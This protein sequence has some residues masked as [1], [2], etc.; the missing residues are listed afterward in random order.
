MSNLVQR[1]IRLAPKPLSE[2]EN[3]TGNPGEVF[4]DANTLSLRIFNGRHSGGYELLR[5][6]FSNIN[7][8]SVD[9]GNR[10]LSATSFAGSVTG[11][12]TGNLTG[13][14][15]GNLTGNVTGNVTGD[16]TGNVN[17]NAATVTNGIYDNQTYENPS[18]LGSV[19]GSK[20]TG[21]VSVNAATATALDTARS[22]NNVSFD[23]T[24]D[25]TVPTLVNGL[26]TVS[27]ASNGNVTVPNVIKLGTV[28]SVS[29]ESTNVIVEGISGN[30]GIRTGSTKNWTFNSAGTLTAPGNITTSTGTVTAAA[31]TVSN[32]VAAGS[33]V[34]SN[35]V[36]VGANVNIPTLPTE[37]QHATNKSYV[38]TRALVMS[39]ALS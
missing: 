13:N 10:A 21:P 2:L 35:D 38:D 9:F 4:L 28:A 37:V 33:A 27:L 1:S 16:L 30:V 24:A 8:T 39:V 23:G 7:G 31:A 18:W 29:S 25:I 17:G 11:N 6:D 19:A 22:I 36:T 5:A 15:T 32:Q 20:I 14:V 3:F 34:V 12:V 26:H